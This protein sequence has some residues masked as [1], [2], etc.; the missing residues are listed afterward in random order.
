MRTRQ[1]CCIQ[2]YWCLIMSSAVFVDRAAGCLIWH[3]Q[4]SKHCQNVWVMP[5]P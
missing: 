1:P 2:L 3:I 4:R 5:S